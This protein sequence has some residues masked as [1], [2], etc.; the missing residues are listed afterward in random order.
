MDN[1]QYMQ[2]AVEKA[3]EGINTGQTPFAACIVKGDR[4]VS[5]EHNAVWASTDS[6]AHAEMRAIRSACH[7]LGTIDLSGCV[8]FTTC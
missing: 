2:L 1:Q 7:E 6:T 4:V 5:C 3:R 8:I